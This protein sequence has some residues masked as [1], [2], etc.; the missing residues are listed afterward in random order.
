MYSFATPPIKL[1]LGTTNRSGN[2]NSKP[3]GPMIM[4]GQLE[5]LSNNYI[6]FITLFSAGA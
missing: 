5:T 3:H 4:M 6:I 2:T 1:K